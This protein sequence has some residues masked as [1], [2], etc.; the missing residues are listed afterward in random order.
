MQNIANM[1]FRPG[2][3][4]MNKYEIRAILGM[5]AFGEVYEVFNRNLGCLS[6]LKLVRVVDPLAHRAVVEAQAQYLCGHDHVVKVTTADVF[7]E[8]VLIEMEYLEDGSL[9]DRLNRQFV[10]VV[11]S[12]SYVK[13]I[14]FAL[15]H[16]H[17]R[18]ILH[19]DI[20][21]ANIMLSGSAAKLSDFGTVL[22]ASS[23]ISVMD[24]SFYRPHAA[25]EAENN[26]EFTP[27][28][29]VFGAGMTLLRAANNNAGWEAVKL[30]PD[31]MVHVKAGS[32]PSKIGFAEYVPTRLKTILKKA[33]HPEKA[34]RLGTAS[35]FRQEL[36]RL[37]PARR[38]FRENTSSWTCE[39]EGRLEELTYAPSRRHEV[40]HLV[41]GR[42]KRAN[43][44]TFDSERQA[45]SHMNKII[46]TTT[47]HGTA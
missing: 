7:D 22:H 1:A 42:R 3:I 47:F 24:N 12:V 17:A 33:L 14:L 25:P 41:A 38:W 19:R 32:L 21:P 11:D 40:I 23:G 46:A 10:P 2:Q 8:A 20:K 13:Q 6:A 36:E 35:Q 31:W 43:C 27:A 29:D 28:G 45:R 30:D 26:K 37:R 4:V 15:E 34:K 9:G 18:G 44:L 16:A 39:F 5:G